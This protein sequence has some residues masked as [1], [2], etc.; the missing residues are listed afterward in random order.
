MVPYW[1]LS[2]GLFGQIGQSPAR[3]PLVS[4][5]LV[6]VAKLIYHL[7]LCHYVHF[8]LNA[9]SSVQFSHSV[10]SNS[11]WPH[12]PQHARPPCPSPTPGVHPNSYP[13]SQWCHPTSHP[14]LSPSS[15][16][17]NLSQHQGL[18]QWVSSS[19]QVAKVLEFQLQHQ[20]FQWTPR[21]GLFRMDWLDLLKGL[22]RV[23]SNTTVQKD[24][25]LG[26]QLSL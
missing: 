15:P 18:F 7:H 5:S 16:A 2:G 11:L 12:E 1:K 3:S 24:Q 8:V 13:L 19:H 14:L 22:S 21:T 20:S 10:V 23:F 25:F 4:G 9:F 26:T 17:L 6:H